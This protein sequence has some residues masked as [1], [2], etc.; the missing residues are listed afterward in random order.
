MFCLDINKIHHMQRKFILNVD[1]NV[2]IEV[3]A[4][5]LISLIT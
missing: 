4:I 2:Y 3:L 1:V 5:T